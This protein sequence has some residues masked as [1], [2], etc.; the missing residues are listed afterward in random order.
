MKVSNLE[1]FKVTKGTSLFGLFSIVVPFVGLSL[2]IGYA[3]VRI[4]LNDNHFINS[5]I[6]SGYI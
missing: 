3:K 6:C 4:N 2:Y 1:H 5:H